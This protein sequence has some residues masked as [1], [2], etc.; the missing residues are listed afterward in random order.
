LFSYSRSEAG[1]S[2]GFPLAFN[3]NGPG[4]ASNQANYTIPALKYSQLGDSAPWARIDKNYLNT[5]LTYFHTFK[6][7]CSAPLW[8]RHFDSVAVCGLD[9]NR[10]A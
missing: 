2:L 7:N 4:G 8:L 10:R 5:S 1:S 3:A 9:A 6:G